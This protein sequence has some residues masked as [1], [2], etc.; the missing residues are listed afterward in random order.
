MNLHSPA[1][2]MDYYGAYSSEESDK[3]DVDDEDQANLDFER[4]RRA[5]CRIMDNSEWGIQA[6]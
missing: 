1:I 2:T 3:S 4:T 5:I 6:L